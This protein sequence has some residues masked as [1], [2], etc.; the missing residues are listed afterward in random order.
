MLNVVIIAS[1]VLCSFCF[2]NAMF[3]LSG[4]NILIFSSLSSVLFAQE[5]IG[6][7]GTQ[8]GGR[9]GC[10]GA[11]LSIIFADLLPCAARL[12]R[13]LIVQHTIITDSSHTG[14]GA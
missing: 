14:E 6:R 10:A 13:R 7:G 4:S 8:E 5:K 3:L 1:R 9:Q 2:G 12:M 11:L